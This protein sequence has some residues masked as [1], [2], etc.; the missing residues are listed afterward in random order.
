MLYH[1]IVD[2]SIFHRKVTNYNMLGRAPLC[3]SLHYTV[4]C[5]LTVSILIIYVTVLDNLKLAVWLL[6]CYHGSCG[7]LSGYSIC[8]YI[9]IIP[10]WR[11]KWL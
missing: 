4:I 1:I 9:M 3:C 10:G 11:C 2:G 5:C 8:I 6:I 7:T